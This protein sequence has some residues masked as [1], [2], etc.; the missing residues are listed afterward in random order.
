MVKKQVKKMS[1]NSFC[2]LACMDMYECVCLMKE[3][4]NLRYLL[5]EK[6]KSVFFS[7][8]LSHSLHTHCKVKIKQ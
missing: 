8:T 3:K 7:F 1:A 5:K 6:Q 4:F 2:R